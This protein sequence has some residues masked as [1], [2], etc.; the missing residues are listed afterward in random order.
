MLHTGGM[1]RGLL[2]GVSAVLLAATAAS[3][4]G[5]PTLSVVALRPQVVAKG[6]GFQ[7]SERVQLRLVGRTVS[8]ASVTASAAGSFRVALTRPVPLDCGRL[9]LRATGSKGS[10]ALA[11]IG[12]AECNPPG[13]STG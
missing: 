10:T 7:P 1:R 13:N 8:T 9:V 11:R 4:A 6:V 5:K 2:I 3:A 12:P